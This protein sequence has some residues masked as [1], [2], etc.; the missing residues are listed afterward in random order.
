MAVLRQYRD[1]KDTACSTYSKA[2]FQSQYTIIKGVFY[3]LHI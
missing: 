2:V 1:I 3:R